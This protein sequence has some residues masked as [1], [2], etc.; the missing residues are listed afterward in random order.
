MYYFSAWFFPPG[1]KWSPIV[2]GCLL[3]FIIWGTHHSAPKEITS[4]HTIT[5]K[6][7]ALVCCFS[8]QPFKT[9]Y[10]IYILSMNFY[11][12]LF[13]YSY[14]F[15]F[16]LFLN[17]WLGV[18]P[19]LFH[20]LIIIFPDFSSYLFFLPDRPTSLFSSLNIVHLALF[21]SCVLNRKSNTTSKR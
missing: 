21:Q 9:N 18:W 4:N 12:S 14:Y 10:P 8:C 11:L 7:P 20:S 13:P 16:I 2:V 5:Y 3:V 19:L 15:P 1:L 17:I 6:Y